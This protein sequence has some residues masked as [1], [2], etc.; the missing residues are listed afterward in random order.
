MTSYYFSIN[1]ITNP[2]VSF[3]ELATKFNEYGREIYNIFYLQEGFPVYPKTK[4]YQ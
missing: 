2:K 4:F 3:T 1:N